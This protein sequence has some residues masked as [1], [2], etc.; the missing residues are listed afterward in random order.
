MLALHLT[1]YACGISVQLNAHLSVVVFETHVDHGDTTKDGKEKKQE[2][3]FFPPKEPVRV[4][5]RPLCPVLGP[6]C[7]LQPENSSIIFFYSLVK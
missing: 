5:V 2:Y 1:Q 3:E 7:L 6:E 4:L